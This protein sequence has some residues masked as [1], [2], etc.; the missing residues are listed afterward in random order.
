MIKDCMSVIRFTRMRLQVYS[1]IIHRFKIWELIP[2]PRSHCGVWRGSV[3]LGTACW[4][5]PGSRGP[6]VTSDVATASK[7]ASE[8]FWLNRSTEDRRAE[9]L[10]SDECVKVVTVNCPGHTTAP[11]AN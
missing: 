5:T 6:S 10:S 8:T 2:E 3:Q 1:V 11:S 7:C 9:R 4:P